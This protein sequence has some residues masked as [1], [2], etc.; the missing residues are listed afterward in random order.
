MAHL[1]LYVNIKARD[2][3]LYALLPKICIHSR[4]ISCSRLFHEL[5]GSL[6]L[7]GEAY[8]MLDCQLNELQDEFGPTQKEN[9]KSRSNLSRTLDQK[10]DLKQFELDCSTPSSYICP[11]I[12]SDKLSPR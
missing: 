2:V 8:I 9:V 7:H 12:Y 5:W 3:R 6:N 10:V 4:D 11:A 1:G